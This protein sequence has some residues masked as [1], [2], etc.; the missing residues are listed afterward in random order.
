MLID[1]PDASAGAGAIVRMG[2]VAYDIPRRGRQVRRVA[3]Q[4]AAQQRRR[5]AAD[6][7]TCGPRRGTCTASPGR[8]EPGR[9]DGAFEVDAPTRPPVAGD[10]VTATFKVL[11][12]LANPAG[13]NPLN[14]EAERSAASDG[15]G[16]R[17]V[18]T[19]PSS[20][21]ALSDRPIAATTVDKLY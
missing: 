18:E 11:A 19:L 17:G 5:V 15:R 8:S 20:A 13:D 3:G 10:C 6:G 1:N 4:H 16:H 7:C 14:N 21:A 12:D 9:H 2:V